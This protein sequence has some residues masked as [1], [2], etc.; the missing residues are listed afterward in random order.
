MKVIYV[1]FSKTGTKTMASAFRI[2]GYKCYDSLEYYTYQ[3]DEWKMIFLKGGTK[4]DF[5]KMLED[6]DATTDV[7]G[8]FYWE[9]I[10]EA[11]PDLKVIKNFIKNIFL[12]KYFLPDCACAVTIEKRR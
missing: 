11:F 4:E 5:K 2:L 1:G 10:L 6:V 9:Q 12:I 8:C 3:K 7:P